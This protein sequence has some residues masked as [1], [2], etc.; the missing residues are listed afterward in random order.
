[1]FHDSGEGTEDTG[2]PAVVGSSSDEAVREEPTEQV[3]KSLL[4][5]A[6]RCEGE[7]ERSDVNRAYLRRGL[8][9]HEC[10]WIE[11]RL[12]LQHV[13]IVDKEDEADDA[14]IEP[15]QPRSVGATGVRSSSSNYLNDSDERE[16]GRRIQL[17][18]RLLQEGGSSD[19]AYDARVHR[20]AEAATI[21]RHIDNVMVRAIT[22][23]FRRRVMLETGRTRPS[24]SPQ[25]RAADPA[26]TARSGLVFLPPILDISALRFSGLMMAPQMQARQCFRGPAGYRQ[27]PRLQVA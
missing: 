12:A 25:A 5:D 4:E 8:A 26:T 1:M 6:E 9:A 23:A 24:R 11:Q 2:D 21:R 22:R 27:P 14:A 7:L 15:D 17:A 19:P 18:R 16:C 13:Q 10:V 20:D 3:L